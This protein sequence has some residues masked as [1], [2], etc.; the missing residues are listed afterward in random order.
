MN[1]PNKPRRVTTSRSLQAAAPQVAD[2]I[3]PHL[4]AAFHVCLRITGDEALSRQ[5]AVETRIAAMLRIE[6]YDGRTAL[7]LW[8]R[9]IARNLALAAVREPAPA[10]D[11]G[12]VTV[13]EAATW[14]GLAPAE[15]ANLIRAA[16][17][18]L[19]ALEQDAV[20]HRY[21]DELPVARVGALLEIDDVARLLDRISG[22]LREALGRALGRHARRGRS[23]A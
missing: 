17:S 5:L 14:H 1:P 2:L 9:G 10:V 12:L 15:R 8:V 13:E 23:V 18:T 4:D 16:A 3:E 19:T 11:D 22:P 6:A 21:V 7:G 20:Y